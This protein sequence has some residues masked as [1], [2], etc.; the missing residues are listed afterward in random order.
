MPTGGRGLVHAKSIESAAIATTLPRSSSLLDRGRQAYNAQRYRDAVVAWEAAVTAFADQPLQQAL[1]L[2]YLTAAYQ[3]LSQWADADRAIT[4]SLDLLTT[5]PGTDQKIAVS[6][7]AHNTLG[8]LQYARGKTQ[9][10]LETWQTAA[11]LYAQTGD[12]ARTINCWLNQVQAL[13]SLGFYRQARDRLSAGRLRHGPKAF[14]NGFDLS[15]TELH[16]DRGDF[17]GVGKY[18]PGSRRLGKRDRPLPTS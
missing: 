15:G 16:R 3:Q 7:Q 12:D 18:G 4:Q 5:I 13:Q 9:S 2:S 11:D 10:A 17:G 14:T 8:S 6:A 1:A